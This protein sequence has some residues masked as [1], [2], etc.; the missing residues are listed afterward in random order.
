MLHGTPLASADRAPCFDAGLSLP[1]AEALDRTSDTPV[2]SELHAISAPYF[3][4]T[5]TTL[6][7]APRPIRPPSP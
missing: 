1:C 3:F 7:E 6:L 4:G 2:A 5:M